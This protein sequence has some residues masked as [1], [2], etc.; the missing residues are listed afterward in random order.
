MDDMSETIEKEDNYFASMTD[1][2]VGVLFI[3]IIT[4]M[5]F[6]LEFNSKEKSLRDIAQ[7]VQQEAQS[8]IAKIDQ[9]EFERVKLLRWI[10]D[11]MEKK[12]VDVIVDEQSGILRLP[13]KELYF[14]S[15]HAEIGDRSRRVVHLLA[16]ALAAMLPCYN[17]TGAGDCPPSFGETRSSLDTILI[18]GHTDSDPVAPFSPFEDNWDLSAARSRNTYRAMTAHIP[19]LA[20]F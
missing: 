16:E 8:E 19:N 11:E 5:L 12:G 6:V 9:A 15:G 1:M 18:E 20:S 17:H 3:F 10:R 7:E 2:M 13:E 14:D 4:L